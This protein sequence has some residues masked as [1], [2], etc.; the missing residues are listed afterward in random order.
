[1]TGEVLNVTN[2]LGVVLRLIDRLCVRGSVRVVRAV[3][4]TLV[5]VTYFWS[6]ADLCPPSLVPPISRSI[7]FAHLEHLGF[8]G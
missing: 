1:M 4:N 7:R 3:N 8:K 5:F 6:I 2:S